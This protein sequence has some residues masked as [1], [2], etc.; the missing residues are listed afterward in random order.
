M[1]GARLRSFRLGDRSELLVEQLLTSIAFTAPVPRQEDH[2]IDFFCNLY[3][4]EGQLL[5]AG[6]FFTVQSKS[7]ADALPYTKAHEL[8]WI[9]N[10]ENPMLLCVA[11]RSALAVDVYSTWNLVCAALN[12][13]RGEQAASRIT[14]VPDADYN[15]WPGV[16][17]HD[18]RSQEVLLGKPIVRITDADT[19]DDSRMQEIADVLGQWVALDRTN[20]VNRYAGMDWVVGPLSYETGQSP[21]ASSQTAVVFYTHPKNL[22]KYL[23]NLGRVA[24]MLTF[25]IRSAQSGI[26]VAQAPWSA[27]MSALQELLRS[28]W[29]LLDDSL[30]KFLTDQGMSP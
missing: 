6:A 22:E 5:K 25:T 8:E 29:D 2:G 14:L 24:T 28:H 20:I 18:D 11:N 10:Q 21:W 13:W 7:K 3:S 12:G 17:D 9:K 27:R 15:V 26:D 19:F 4:Y 30:R 1:P 16:E 23:I